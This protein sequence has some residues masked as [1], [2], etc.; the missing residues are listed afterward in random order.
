MEG[1]FKGR[2]D[3]VFDLARS[4]RREF[5]GAQSNQ[6]ARCSG[7]TS[8]GSFTPHFQMP[9]GGRSVLIGRRLLVRG[10]ECVQIQRFWAVKQRVKMLA[11]GLQT[12]GRDSGEC[13][14]NVLNL[15]QGSRRGEAQTWGKMELDAVPDTSNSPLFGA[16]NNRNRQDWGHDVTLAAVEQRM[17]GV[18]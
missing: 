6:E 16:E 17:M 4:Q 12:I 9:D 1:R 8:G 13:W 11:R 10:P 5:G 15:E 14:C 18:M 3:T 2:L 7:Q